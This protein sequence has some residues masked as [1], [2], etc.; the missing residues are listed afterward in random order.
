M[1]FPAL[2]ECSQPLATPAAEMITD[3]DA[4]RVGWELISHRDYSYWGGKRAVVVQFSRGCPYQCNYCGQR[5]FWTRWRHRD[6]DDKPPGPRGGPGSACARRNRACWGR[7]SALSEVTSVRMQEAGSGPLGDGRQTHQH[8]IGIM[9]R[10]Q[11]ELGATVIKEKN[12]G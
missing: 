1:A 7:A 11:P 2:H 3:L 4:Y 10:F 8:G 5:G 12:K 9:P 6:R